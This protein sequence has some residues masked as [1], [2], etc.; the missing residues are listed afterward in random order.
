M[1]SGIPFSEGLRT[2][3]VTRQESHEVNLGEV[4][5]SL[6]CHVTSNRIR[7]NGLELWQER[8]RL[9]VRKYFSKSGQ[10][11]EWAAQ[12]GGGVTNPGSAQ[13]MFRC[14][15]EGF[16]LVG[17]IGERWTVGLDDLGGLFQPW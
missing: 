13:E 3:V 9:D 8:F 16:G 10:V 1:C 15:T 4:G 12:G 17:N 6:L 11:M 5:V 2:S 14:C 7:G